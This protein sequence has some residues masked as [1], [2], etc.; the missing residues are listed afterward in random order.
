MAQS[1]EIHT[2]KIQSESGY[3]HGWDGEKCIYYTKEKCLYYN[4]SETP[5][6]HC[7][8]YTKKEE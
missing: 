1:K 6:H 7:H 5:C 8:H 2:E 3:L 4:D